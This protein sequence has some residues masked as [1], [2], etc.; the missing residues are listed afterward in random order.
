MQLLAVGQSLSRPIEAPS[1][2]RMVEPG[3]LPKFHSDEA[4][5]EQGRANAAGMENRQ[6]EL[7][8]TA[9]ELECRNPV[10]RQQVLPLAE[11]ENPAMRRPVVEAWEAKPAAARIRPPSKNRGRWALPPGVA[12]DWLKQRTPARRYASALPEIKVMRNDLSNEDLALVFARNGGGATKA[13]EV[14]VAS[15]NKGRAWSRMVARLFHAY[16]A[17]KP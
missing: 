4:P 10:P 17:E 2:F 12:Q 6:I 8:P 7:A 5:A 11:E 9:T 16:L 3:W 14:Q 13:G 1:R 15:S